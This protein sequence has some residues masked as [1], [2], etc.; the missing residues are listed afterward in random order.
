[1]TIDR[2]GG[3][4]STRGGSL[5]ALEQ[6]RLRNVTLSREYPED[7]SPANET[8]SRPGLTVLPGGARSDVELMRCFRNGDWSGFEIL[9]GRYFITAYLIC[10]GSLTCPE[11]ALDSV[12]DTFLAMLA[13]ADHLDPYRLGDWLVSTAHYLAELRAHQTLPP[14][15]RVRLRLISRYGSNDSGTGEQP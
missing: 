8:D 12:N 13:D 5:A 15:D 14:T 1:V 9:Y 4:S 7:G 6:L 3:I 2:H 10:R 11:T